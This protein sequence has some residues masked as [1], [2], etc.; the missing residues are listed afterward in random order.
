LSLSRFSTD[1]EIDAAAD[2]VAAVI[3]RLARVMPMTT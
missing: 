2:A 1:A 3:A